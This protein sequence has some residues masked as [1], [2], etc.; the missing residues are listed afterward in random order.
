MTRSILPLALA[1]AIMPVAAH[2]ADAPGV[3]PGGTLLTISAEG[4]SARTP[5][6][7]TFSTGVTST[8]KSASAAMAANAAAMNRVIAALKAAGIAP[9][10]IQTASLSLNPVYED[11]SRLPPAEQ[12]EN[13]PPRVV[14]YQAGNTVSVRTRDLSR[15]GS[16]IDALVSAGANQVNGPDFALDQPD[17]ALDE[18]RLAAMKSAR[19][20]ADLYAR[21]AG[22]HVVRVLAI[23][24]AGGYSPQP[25]PFYAAKVEAMAA[26]GP[27]EA[28]EVAMTV[29]VTVQYELAP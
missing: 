8:G 9:R 15:M 4:K 10:D 14:G 25:R 23:A 20:R 16:V 11:Q 24:E 12:A 6:L 18:A 13:R 28:G 27:V 7:A 26:P 1:A 17:A 21:A 19:A 5:D 29:N 2:A 3:A 22:L